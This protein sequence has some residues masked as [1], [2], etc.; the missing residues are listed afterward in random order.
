[1]LGLPA[2]PGGLSHLPLFEYFGVPLDLLDQV[3]VLLHLL[4]VL[5]LPVL[6]LFLDL[7]VEVHDVLAHLLADE[8]LL[9]VEILGFP[10]TLVHVVDALL[11]LP[12]PPPEHLVFDVGQDVGPHFVFLIAFGVLHQQLVDLHLLSLLRVV[13]VTFLLLFVEVVEEHLPHAFD[14]EILVDVLLEVLVD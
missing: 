12:L 13:G 4:F 2:G 10:E 14:F 11:P 5:L 3:H 8:A 9:S 6:K 7:L 1:M